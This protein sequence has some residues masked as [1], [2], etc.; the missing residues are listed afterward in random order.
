MTR[1][2]INPQLLIWARERAGIDAHTLTHHFPKLAEWEV[3]T[4][5]PTLR[6]LEEFAHTVHVAVGYLFLPTPPDER[7]PIADFRTIGGRNSGRPSPNLLDTIYLCQ[8]R[9]DWFRDY[10]R[11]HALPSHSFVGSATINDDPEVVAQAMRQVLGISIVERQKQPSWTDALRQLIRDADHAGILV[12]ASGIVGSNSHRKLSVEE[13]RG[14]ALADALAP[15]IFINTTDSKAAQMFTVAHELAHIWLGKSGVSNPTIVQ[16]TKPGIE[17][18]CNA[19]A[20]EFLMPLAM[21]KTQNID[22]H[23]IATEIQTLAQHFKVSTLVVL[24]RLYDAGFINKTTFH[25]RYEDELKRIQNSQ[26]TGGGGNFYRTLEARTS[27]RFARAVLSST[28]EGHTLF[29]D[30]FHLLGVRKTATFYSAA[31]EL[32][33]IK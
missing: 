7:L 10:A 32:E 3:G 21:I 1:V 17:R 6:Q 33:V 18:W 12:M 15:L 8:Q 30:A 16:S 24:R 26:K 23:T 20:A 27:T 4:L 28:L 29:R 11:I 25:D 22:T 13:F 9:Q 14:F 31:R 2:P 5:Q 19:V